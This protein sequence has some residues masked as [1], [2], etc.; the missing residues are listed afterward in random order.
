MVQENVFDEYI[1]VDNNWEIIGSTQ[2]DLTGY[3][4]ET[5]V[6]A[7]I[8]DFLTESEITNLVNT[9]LA[10]YYT[11]GQVDSLLSN[12]ADRSLLDN[13]VTDVQINETS[14]KSSGVANIPYATGSQAGVVK[15]SFENTNAPLYRDN[16]GNIKIGRPDNLEIDAKT[17][18]KAILCSNYDYAVKVGVTTNTN[19][20]TSAEKQQAQSWLGFVTLTQAQYDALVQA[21]TVDSGTYY[22]IIEE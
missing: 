18:D 13:Y 6:T 20:L 12:K 3:A 4:T 8:S 2:I 16:Q 11:K 7:Q 5:W 15:V 9:A 14:I 10:N 1:W 19:T 22:Y 21:G 17:Q